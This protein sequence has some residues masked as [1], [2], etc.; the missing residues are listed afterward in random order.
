MSQVSAGRKNRLSLEVNGSRSSLAWNVEEPNELWIGRRDE[1]N[2][3]LLKSPPLLSEEAR[4]WANY[5]GGHAEGYPD[6]FKQLF[7]AV[8]A[9]IDGDSTARYPTFQ[10]GA[11]AQHVC[12]AIAV[13]AREERWV[14]VERET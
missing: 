9:A 14:E 13:S 6:T 10:D 12:D 8:Y 3:L 1:P 11:D 5:P 7:R 2:G 4:K